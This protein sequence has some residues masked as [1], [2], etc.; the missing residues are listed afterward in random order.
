MCVCALL[1]DVHS[2]GPQ[3]ME[4]RE[5]KHSS[6]KCKQPFRKDTNSISVPRKTKKN[7]KH[8][9]IP[10]QHWIPEAFN[11]STPVVPQRHHAQTPTKP[12]QKTSRQTTPI[13]P[14]RN[15]IQWY[16]ESHLTKSHR[17]GH[18][19]G[20]FTRGK[21]GKWCKM[22]PAA[23]CHCRLFLRMFFRFCRFRHLS[24]LF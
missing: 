19:S 2:W 14:D 3:T 21:P 23:I 16:N 5:P 7:P 12:N 15:M 4:N 9:A 22:E 13:D 18:T 1:Q 10:L 11:N 17:S 24:R 20:I 8:G 6:W